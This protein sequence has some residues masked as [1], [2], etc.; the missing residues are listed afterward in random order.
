VKY[1]LKKDQTTEDSSASNCRAR[2][3]VFVDLACDLCGVDLQINDSDTEATIREKKNHY[4]EVCP[5]VPG[6]PVRTDGVFS[7]KTAVKR[8]AAL[9]LVK[10]LRGTASPVGPHVYSSSTSLTVGSEV[11]IP[12]KENPPDKSRES[13]VGDVIH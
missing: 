9:G 4:L 1:F 12:H 5:A 8:M 10:K 11:S 6:V 7:P 3:D 2:S 13:H